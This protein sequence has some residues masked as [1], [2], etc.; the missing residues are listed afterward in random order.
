MLKG[1]LG[2]VIAATLT[3]LVPAMAGAHPGHAAATG[4]VAGLLHPLTG[5]DHLLAMLAVGIWSVQLGGRARYAVPAAFVLAMIG[6][7][8]LGSGQPALTTVEYGI[9]GSVLVLGLLIALAARMPLSV[10]AAIVASFAVLHGYAHATD[11]SQSGL[12]GT[13]IAGMA[14]GTLMLHWIGMMA[15]QIAAGLGR[16]DSLRLRWSGGVI[17][18]AGLLLLAV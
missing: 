8:L 5:I 1:S 18:T 2:R 11:A 4:A 3:L 9:Q 6:G 16:R 15:A 17:A 13:F 14:I 10:S 12:S 7:A